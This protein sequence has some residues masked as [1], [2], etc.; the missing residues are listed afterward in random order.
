MGYASATLDLANAMLAQIAGFQ[1]FVG[2]VDTPGAAARIVKVD[3]APLSS[4]NYAKSMVIM[5]PDEETGLGVFRRSGEIGIA[6]W[7]TD[8]TADTPAGR[9][10]ALY[11]IADTVRTGLLALRGSVGALATFTVALGDPSHFDPTTAQKGKGM[12]DITIRFRG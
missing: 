4:G 8:E 9:A 3:S 1:T 10:E 12:I 5:D 11:D 2:A 6:L 7:R